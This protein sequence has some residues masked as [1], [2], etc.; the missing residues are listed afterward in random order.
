MFP[1]TID[2]LSLRHR[3]GTKDYH[4]VQILNANGRGLLIKRW[5]KA[6]QWGQVQIEAYSSAYDLDKAF[7]K[8]RSTKESRGYTMEVGH[9]SGEAAD[10]AE[11]LKALGPQYAAIPGAQ[12][13]HVLGDDD[14]INQI[15][16]DD[17]PDTAD[18][19]KVGL[20]REA[21]KRAERE[22]AKT[23]AAQEEAELKSNPQWGIF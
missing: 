18:M 19:V 22:A 1:I 20:E 4:L 16:G 5:G 11:F 9:W 12:F 21:K 3:G 7:T 17:A 14:E 15:L 2:K 23:K 10:N 13:D 6:G 8:M